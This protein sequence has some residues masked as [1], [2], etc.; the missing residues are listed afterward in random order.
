MAYFVYSFHAFLLILI[1]MHSMFMTAPF[2]SSGL[3][4]FRS[5]AILA[6]FITVVIFPIVTKDG[7]VVSANMGEFALMVL[8][9]VI[10]GVYIGFLA[11]IVFSA[12]QLSG[13]FF[14]VQIG[15][16]ISEVMDPLAQVSVPIIGQLKNMIGL[17]VFLYING[18]HFL[19]TAVY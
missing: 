17:L 6:F 2:Y 12:F 8:R 13:Q 14:A 7:Y 1:R 5:K 16:G 15:F 11:S 10:I 9:E 4:S 19:I 18:H 3:V